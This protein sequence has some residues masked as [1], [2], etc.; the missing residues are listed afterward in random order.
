MIFFFTPSPGHILQYPYT[1]HGQ[2]Q[3]YSETILNVDGAPSPLK[4]FDQN[5]I[6]AAVEESKP[7]PILNLSINMSQNITSLYRFLIICI[8]VKA[9]GILGYIL[10]TVLFLSEPVSK[11]DIGYSKLFRNLN[12]IEQLDYLSKHEVRR[13]C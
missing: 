10:C 11:F 3:Q 1:A 13:K 5:A 8:E 2:H 6:S 12:D 4:I 9:S 7:T